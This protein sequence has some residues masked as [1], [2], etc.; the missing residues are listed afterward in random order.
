MSAFYREK[1]LAVRHWTDTLFSFRATRDSGFRFQ[2][3]Q[4]AMI[5]LEVDGRPAA[6][7]AID[8]AAD[9]A[10]LAAPGWDDSSTRLGAGGPL[11]DPSVL[12]VAGQRT[13]RATV[14]RTGELVVHDLTDDARR[15]RR[16]HTLR[17]ALAAGTS[18]APVVDH[19]GRVVGVVVLSDAA[20]DR[21]YAVDVAEV[22]EL[23]DASH[24][25]SPN[26]SCSAD[27]SQD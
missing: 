5:G 27:A 21:S 18:G 25:P 12:V 11:D 4:F 15:H 17:P 6:V 8:D 3:G 16:A 26:D 13:T 20:H 19:E 10:V 24:D 9:L 7:V 23:L 2:N 14:L 22:H 1:V